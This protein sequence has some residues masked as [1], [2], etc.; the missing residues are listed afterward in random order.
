MIRGDQVVHAVVSFALFLIFL[1][2]A[3]RSVW[4]AMGAAVLAAIVGIGKE[5]HDI[6]KTGFD[7][8]DII[9]DFAGIGIA[10]A[11]W[12]I[13]MVSQLLFRNPVL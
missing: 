2:A 12:G 11:C 9:A 6:W 8:T 10:L 4:W 13:M 7:W 1:A 3:Q 5:I